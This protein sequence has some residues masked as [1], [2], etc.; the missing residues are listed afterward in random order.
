MGGYSR[1]EKAA[2]EHAEHVKASLPLLPNDLY[3]DDQG[4]LHYADG[5][6]LKDGSYRT[7]EGG[8]MMYEGQMANCLVFTD[9]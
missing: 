8:V 4:L 7:P 1:R 6:L 9:I 5:T 2:R 3:E